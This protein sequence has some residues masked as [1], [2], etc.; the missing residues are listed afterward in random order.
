MKGLFFGKDGNELS[1]RKEMDLEKPI[2]GFCK[3]KLVTRGYEKSRVRGWQQ[4][5]HL[6]PV[7]G[8]VQQDQGLLAR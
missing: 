3:G 7:G 2:I 5:L 4:W 6:H 8:V 1:Y